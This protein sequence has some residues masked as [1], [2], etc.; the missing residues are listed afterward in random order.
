MLGWAA[1]QSVRPAATARRGHT[2]HRSPLLPRRPPKPTAYP[3]SW[4]CTG[5]RRMG[6][7]FHTSCTRVRHD[8]D[9]RGKRGLCGVGTADIG[10]PRVPWRH[11]RNV[12]GAPAR[13]VRPAELVRRSSGSSD[14]RVGWH[15]NEMCRSGR[16]LHSYGSPRFTKSSRP[17]P[18]SRVLRC[19]RVA[20]ASRRGSG[21]V[22]VGRLPRVA[23]SRWVC[24]RTPPCGARVVPTDTASSVARCRGVP[25]A[26]AMEPFTQPVAR[27]GRPTDHA[28]CFT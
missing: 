17:P 20:V 10:G 23:Q 28:R 13:T 8:V 26:M 16:R 9:H 4:R 11:C 3:P 2:G 21:A 12:E 1:F 24:R 18:A 22:M 19:S 7:A 25:S 5:S 27:S 14:C 6:V 15:A